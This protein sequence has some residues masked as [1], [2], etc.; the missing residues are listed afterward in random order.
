MEN[1]HYASYKKKRAKLFGR[2]HRFGFC[3]SRY[4]FW[5]PPCSE[6]LLLDSG[7]TVNYTTKV[8][9]SMR[10]AKKYYTKPMFWYLNASYCVKSTGVRVQINVLKRVTLWKI[11]K[12]KCRKLNAALSSSV[13]LLLEFARASQKKDIHE[14]CVA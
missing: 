12:L 5:T 13:C 6:N 1:S 4:I 7:A 9:H 10:L 3:A 2:L 11:L 8:K 14:V